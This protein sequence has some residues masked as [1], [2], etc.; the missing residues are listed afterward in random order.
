VADGLTVV[1][2]TRD[3]AEVLARFALPSL[4]AL[5]GEGVD[6]LV[7]DQSA[8]EATRRLVEAARDVRYARSDPGLS[9]G[10]NRALELVPSELIAFV[11]DDV[12]FGPGWAAGLA[13]GFGGDRVGAVCGRGRTSAGRLYPGSEAGVYTWPT[14][15]F[16]L[17]SGFNL[18]LRVAAAREVG[19]F[20]EELGAGGRFRAGE[21][22]DMLYRLLR[23]GWVVVCTDDADVVHHEW[24]SRT[25]EVALH[26]GYGVGAGAQTAAHLRAGDR[27]AGRVARREAAKHVRTFARAVVT[28]QPRVAA[29]QPPF[30]AG[31]LVGYLRAMRS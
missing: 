23:S 26:F 9:R 30:L 1:V 17:G 4:A 20:D 11:D 22:T 29:L 7:V 24:R 13:A 5:A 31:L 10:R 21:D 15:P 2:V 19:G 16:G 8:D 12:S 18:A 25:D 28:M 27:E 6:A 3:R 14:N